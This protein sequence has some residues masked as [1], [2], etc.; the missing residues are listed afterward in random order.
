MA[1]KNS[2]KQ[3][4]ENGIYH[5]YNRGV[6]KRDIFVDQQDFA[7]FLSYLKTYLLPKDIDVLSLILNSPES[8]YHQKQKAEKELALKNFSG[9]IDLLAF[10]LLPNHF[11]LLIH[12]HQSDGIDRF[13]NAFGVR[14]TGY[15][16][17]KYKRVGPLLQGVYKAVLIENELLLLHISRYI[18]LNPFIKLGLSPSQLKEVP[19]PFS[20]ADY[21]GLKHTD[22]LKPELV[23]NYFSKTNAG[24][25]YKDFMGDHDPDR[26]PIYEL[27]IDADDE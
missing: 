16:N 22:W 5:I 23:L 26:K 21:Y 7:V 12:Q 24:N 25:T 17:R 18:H 4:L 2:V 10:A 13:M 3:Y 6:E 20:L 1:A 14:Y 27:T 11:H 8:S 15:F 9:E 19:W